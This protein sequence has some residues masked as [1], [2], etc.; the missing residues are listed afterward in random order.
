VLL[1]NTNG[2]LTRGRSYAEAP[3]VD[4]SI[5]LSAKPHHREGL[6]VRARLT[7][8]RDYDILGEELL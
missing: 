4:G 5:L 7:Q 1:E 8:A 6:Y 2:S 3:E